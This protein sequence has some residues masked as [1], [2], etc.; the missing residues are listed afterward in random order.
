MGGKKH[1]HPAVGVLIVVVVV[2]ILIRSSF[3]FDLSSCVASDF[4]FFHFEIAFRHFS[5]HICLKFMYA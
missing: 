2:I 5:K 1:R 3:V 4:A